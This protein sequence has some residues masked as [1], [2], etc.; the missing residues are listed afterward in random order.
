MRRLPKYIFFLVALAMIRCSINNIAGGGS[1][2]P[3]KVVLG[4]IFSTDDLPAAN[5][6]VMIIPAKYNSITDG[7]I[8]A[9]LID[10]TDSSGAFYISR[11]VAG[12]YNIQAVHISMRT[13]L[14]ITGLTVSGDTTKVAADTLRLSGVV[15]VYLPDGIATANCRVYFPGTTIASQ[16]RATGYAI[17]DS[18]PAGKI[19]SVCYVT[20]NDSVPATIRYNL[21]VPAG[22]T[23]VVAK[24][25]WDYSRRLYLNTTASGA[26]VAGSVLNFPVLVRLTSDNFDFSQAK[27][28]G[29][30]VRF[31]KADTTELPY[32]IERWDAANRRA[33]I[34][35]CLDTVYGNSLDHF[36]TMYWGNAVSV[37]AS[38]G[39]T[40]FD[41]GSGFQGVWHLSETGNAIVK[42]ATGNHY[43]GTPSDTA[44]LSAEGTIGPCRSFNGLSN[45]IRMN[46]TANGK[47]NFQE[48]GIY[49]ISA[50]AY[51]D[52]LDNGYHIVVGKSNEQYYLK[53]KTSVPVSSSM[54][55]EFVEYHDK[56]GWYIS[57]SLPVIPSAKTWVYIVGVKNGTTQYF[58]VNGE[59]ID[60]TISVTA[61]DVTRNTEDDV[62]IGKFLS[63]AATDTAEGKCPF[64][65]KID[66]VRISNSAKN[67]DWIKLCYMNQKT[68]DALVKW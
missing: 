23:A 45:Y 54:V 19:P 43:D 64:L 56:A 2:L 62:T 11:C 24:P 60:S 66:E 16:A 33:E 61:A 8:P 15:K 39:T 34:W 32:E 67:T 55:W 9:A 65:G 26:Q 41:T 5:T 44:P 10:T 3:D 28:G 53:F 7:P 59:L 49:T 20:K 18:V 57:N 27:A 58:Y 37:S 25:A 1:D 4:K 68:S 13:R 50:W 36:F 52:T 30:D 63:V 38:K 42:D 47:L 6:Q 48:N 12:D 14:L 31:T 35:V 40:V 29:E 22:D 17:L 51:A 21:I 46:G